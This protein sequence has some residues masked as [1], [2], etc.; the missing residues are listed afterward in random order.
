MNTTAIQ[1]ARRLRRQKCKLIKKQVN[2]IA[3]ELQI[4]TFSCRD[5][6][7]LLNQGQTNV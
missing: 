5:N 1:Q 4:I 2:E 7:G 6:Q 3:F